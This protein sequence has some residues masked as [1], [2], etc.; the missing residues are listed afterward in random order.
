MSKKREGMRQIKA[1]E[2]ELDKL[3]EG[4]NDL[5]TAIEG[6][7]TTIKDMKYTL[8]FE[9]LSFWK[10]IELKKLIRNTTKVHCK[11]NKEYLGIAERYYE[12]RDI[13]NDLVRQI[14]AEIEVDKRTTQGVRG[15]LTLSR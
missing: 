3:C 13:V 10:K 1:L 4:K 8:K 7:E 15:G 2:R 12:R 6:M 5:R 9:K 11:C 14:K